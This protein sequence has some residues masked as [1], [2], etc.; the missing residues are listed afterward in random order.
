MQVRSKELRQM[1]KRKKEAHK[2]LAKT[3]TGA[4]AEAAKPAR[5]TKKSEG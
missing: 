2:A 3:T 5:A 1:W 4:T